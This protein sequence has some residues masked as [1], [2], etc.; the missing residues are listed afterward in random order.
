MANPPKINSQ[1]GLRQDLRE[2]S[3]AQ[4]VRMGDRV[5]DRLEKKEE[6]QSPSVIVSWAAGGAEGDSERRALTIAWVLTALLSMKRIQ[7]R[8]DP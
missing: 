7:T 6:V 5:R 2:S 8:R 1:M 3:P 4:R